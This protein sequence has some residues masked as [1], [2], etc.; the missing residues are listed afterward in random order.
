MTPAFSGQSR[1][2]YNTAITLVEAV[3]FFLRP[4]QGIMDVTH[5]RPQKKKNESPFIMVSWKKVKTMAQNIPASE[6]KKIKPF[7]L[8]NPSF[9]RYPGPIS[10]TAL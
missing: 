7:P 6:A 2:R 8:L 10:L 4:L 1:L 5:G 9:P 3:L